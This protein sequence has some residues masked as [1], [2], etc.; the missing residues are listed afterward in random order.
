MPAKLTPARLSAIQ[1]KIHPGRFLNKFAERLDADADDILEALFAIAKGNTQQ[2]KDGSW[3][4]R[5]D[6]KDT[7]AAIKCI[8]DMGAFKETVKHL[9]KVAQKGR[10]EADGEEEAWVKE[11]GE[12]AER[13]PRRTP[14]AGGPPKKG[15]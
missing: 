12:I 1:A 5:A 13:A 9:L 6:P 8:L 2:M 15:G 4:T 14:R 11:Y 7:I 10:P 3:V